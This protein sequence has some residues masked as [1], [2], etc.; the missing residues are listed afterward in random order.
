MVQQQNAV[1]LHCIVLC[2]ALGLAS[3]SEGWLAFYMSV[4]RGPCPHNPSMLPT[5]H[6]K[7]HFGA[8]CL[9]I[10]MSSFFDI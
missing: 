9:N 10:V 3:I 6:I 2:L 4:P 7:S 1:H 5:V 8:F